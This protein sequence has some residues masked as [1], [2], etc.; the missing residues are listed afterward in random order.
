MNRNAAAA[1]YLM[2]ETPEMFTT[3]EVAKIVFQPDGDEELRN[4][5]RKVRYYFDDGYEHLTVSE[6]QDDGTAAYT[7][8]PDKV[9]AGEGVM[10][11][12]GVDGMVEI[13]FGAVLV[14]ES[15]DGKPQALKLETDE[16]L[17]AVEAPGVVETDF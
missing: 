16:D 12:A 3:T 1:L 7:A 2:R 11:V 15:A 8:D 13:D 6:T 4:A 5:E 10:H 17:P 9:W 14:Y